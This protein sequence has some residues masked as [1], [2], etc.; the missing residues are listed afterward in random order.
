MKTCIKCETEKRYEDFRTDNDALYNPRLHY[1]CKACLNETDRNLDWDDRL[2]NLINEQ[3]L[4]I[5]HGVFKSQY[6]GLLKDSRSPENHVRPYQDNQ[7]HLHHLGLA[8]IDVHKDRGLHNHEAWLSSPKFQELW[9][10]VP[11]I[12]RHA[13]H[14]KQP[15]S[16]FHKENHENWVKNE[17]WEYATSLYESGVRKERQGN[18]W[19]KYLAIVGGIVILIWAV[20]SYRSGSSDC[21]DSSETIGDCY[22]ARPGFE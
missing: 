15:C 21:F 4:A 1:L 12:V 16:K 8:C 6:F 14:Q 7:E 20:S 5:L 22:D 18:E 10:A 17:Q 13:Q 11:E 9:D 2:T 3:C 19:F